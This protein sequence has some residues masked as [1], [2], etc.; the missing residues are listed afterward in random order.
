MKLII[1][2]SFLLL[3]PVHEIYAGEKKNQKVIYKYK[4]YEKF[5]LGNLEIKGSVI[6]PRRFIG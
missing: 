6:A 2:L 1:L 4:S 5:D 3:L